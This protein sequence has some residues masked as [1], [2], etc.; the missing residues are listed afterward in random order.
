MPSPHGLTSHPPRRQL[1]L[2]D[3]FLTGPGSSGPNSSNEPAKKGGESLR[4]RPGKKVVDPVQT[5][6][7][8]VGLEIC[9]DI[10]SVFPSFVVSTSERRR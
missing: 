5:E 10:R 7:G 4:V 8:K 2:F 1:H 9:Y 3:V 6:I